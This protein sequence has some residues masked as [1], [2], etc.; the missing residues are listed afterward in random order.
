MKPFRI[1]GPTALLGLAV[2]LVA[3]SPPA[4]AQEEGPEGVE[5]QARGPVHEAFAAPGDP[6]P[7]A[8]PVVNKE[9][10]EPIEEQPPEQRPEG[11][12][13]VWIPGYWGWDDES[14]DFLWVSGFWREAPPDRDWIP[15]TWQ[16]A[17]DGWR[18]VNGFWA[19][20]EVEEVQYLPEPPETLER[21]PTTPAPDANH[22]YAPGCWVWRDT[23]YAWRPGVWL[24]H[25][26]NWVWVAARYVWS[27]A[28]CVFVDGY[29]DHPLH[30]R[31]LLFAPVRFNRGVLV[32][33]FVYRPAFV[34]QPDFLL[35]ALFVRPRLGCYSFGDY[36]EA[37]YQRNFIPW[38]DYRPARNVYDANFRYYRNAYARQNRWEDSLR[39]LYAAR[40]RGDV[41]RPPR[42]LIQQNKVV[43]NIKNQNTVVNKNVN[44]TNVQ[45]VSVVAPITKINNT[46]VTALANL[47]GQ[48]DRGP[49]TKVVKLQKVD[50][51]VQKRIKERNDDLRKVAVQRR[52]VESKGKIT[53]KPDGKPDVKP[54]RD[55]PRVDTKLPLV[56]P[57]RPV[58]PSRDPKVRKE[59]PPPPRHA[60][61]DR[62]RKPIRGD[63]K[64]PPRTTPP[65]V[66]DKTPPRTTPPRTT[67]PKKDDDKTPP[68]TT[69]PRTTPPPKKDDDR[70]PPRQDDKPPRTV[71]P[72]RT[73]PPTP[74]R[75]PPPPPPKKDDKPD[76][77]KNG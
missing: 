7:E 14:D 3:W 17:D 12:N 16:R 63:D 60:A 65:R 37:R 6:Q 77:K 30:D 4:P 24:A 54:D 13:I 66:D 51:D 9:P 5:V 8:T 11:D 57:K 39:S 67:P 15:G 21:G 68:R 27:P 73:P 58:E 70:K 32:R 35:T 18:W 36:Y 22:F 19:A 2:C 34:I 64:T 74:P 31:G 28:G 23:R 52:D 40:F 59:P 25:R 45:N 20:D 46:R 1:M 42:T 72:P 49:E 61:E 43:N 75:T 10:P 56:K 53:R 76:K 41:A 29:W 71:P 48:G 38:I 55:P 47:T 33:S 62:I 69:P 26:P 50:V 44:I